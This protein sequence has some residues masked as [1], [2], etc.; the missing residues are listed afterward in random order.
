MDVKKSEK[1]AACSKT[2]AVEQICS[3]TM[4]S[5]HEFVPLRVKEKDGSVEMVRSSFFFNEKGK[6]EWALTKE[7][8]ERHKR[9]N[10][11]QVHEIDSPISNTCLTKIT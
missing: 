8:R 11:G 7:E 2:T 9:L 3:W 4:P 10:K 5:C 6:V 1:P